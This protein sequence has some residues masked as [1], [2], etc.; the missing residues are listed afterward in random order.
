MT[1]IKETIHVL[2][3]RKVNSLFHVKVN[4]KKKIFLELNHGMEISNK[5]KELR[6]KGLKIN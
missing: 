3:I 1:K 4:L 5:D 6:S 2:V